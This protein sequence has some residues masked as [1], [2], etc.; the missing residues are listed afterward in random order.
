MILKELK[1]FD[2]EKA[3]NGATIVDGCHHPVKILKYD[4]KSVYPILTIV[5]KGEQEYAKKYNINGRIS[6]KYR[7]HDDDLYILE[8]Y[9]DFETIN[10][11]H[12]KVVPLE[13]DIKLCHK[14]IALGKLFKIAEYYNAQR[15][16]WTNV[17][18]CKYNIYY[19]NDTKTYGVTSCYLIDDG[20]P[21][22]L[23]EDHAWLVVNNPNFKEI[24]DTTFIDV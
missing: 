8:E 15:V 20:C 13:K 6:H 18:Q 11:E 4:L 3:K 10:E 19:N 17:N 5:T 7:F 14:L 2:V 16:D 9:I 24:L 23:N 22:F 21:C 12:K 1:P